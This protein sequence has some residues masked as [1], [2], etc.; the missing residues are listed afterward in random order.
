PG[1]V[2]DL[3][4]ALQQSVDKAR[5]SRGEAADADVHELTRAKKS[6]AK[7]TPA[8]KTAAKTAKKTTTAKKTAKKTA[9]R[10]PRS[11]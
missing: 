9:G 7:K 6:P 3:M 2:L 11:A 10:K 5:S 4:S 1:Q 8:K